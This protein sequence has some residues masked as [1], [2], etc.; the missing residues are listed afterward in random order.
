MSTETSTKSD[1]DAVLVN[2]VIHAI[3]SVLSSMANTEAQFKAVDAQENY[4]A[5][6]D[7]SAVIGISGEKGEGMF[8]LSFPGT[9]AD[10][11]IGRLLGMDASQ[12]SSEDRKDGVAE[13]VNMVSGSVKSALSSS[14]GTTYKLSL[15]TVIQ[16]NNHEISTGP[17]NCPYLVVRFEAEGQPFQLQVSFKTY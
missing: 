3:T 13:L 11:L 1:L 6:G 12:I 9:L 14:S 15:P 8:S 5:T 10:L 7:I 17:R 4:N 2:A 16:G